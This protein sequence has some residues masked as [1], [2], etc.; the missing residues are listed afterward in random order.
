MKVIVIRTL[1]LFFFVSVASVTPGFAQEQKKEDVF[2]QQIENRATNVINETMTAVGERV[3]DFNRRMA[4]IYALTPLE[5][6]NLDSAKIIKNSQEIEN[7][8]TF[9]DTYRTQAKVLTKTLTDSISSLRNEL[10]ANQ[11]KSFLTSFEKAYTKDATAFDGYLASLSK[12]FRRVKSSLEFLRYAHYTMKAS[13][14]EFEHEADH[15]RYSEFMEGVQIA[16]AELNKA[17]EVSKIA[18]AEANQ[19]MQDVYGKN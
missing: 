15:K 13:S 17:A 11:R 18:T 7:F 19:V 6:I 2:V 12:L 8:L 16:T 4:A 9:I 14:I 10:P 5:S 3:E 1:V